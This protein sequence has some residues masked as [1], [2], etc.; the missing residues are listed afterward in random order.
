MSSFQLMVWD[1]Q[2]NNSLIVILHIIILGK[3]HILQLYIINYLHFGCIFQIQSR[4]KDL[5]RVQI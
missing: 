1:T 2:H 4:G 5:F 3:F